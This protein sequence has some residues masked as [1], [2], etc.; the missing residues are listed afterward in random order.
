MAECEL[1]PRCAFFNNKI[2]QFVMAASAEIIKKR[3]CLVDNQQCARYR[4]IKAGGEE[5]NI[6]A[7]LLPNMYE[8]AETIIK[9]LEKKQSLYG[10]KIRFR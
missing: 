2:G 5:K 10:S 7:D 9:T 8:R 3:Y 6:P 1:R 4:I